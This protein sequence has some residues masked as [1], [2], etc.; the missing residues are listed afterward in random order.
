MKCILVKVEFEN[1]QLVADTLL[2][3]REA[4]NYLAA[5]LY[6]NRPRNITDAHRWYKS[7]RRQ[8]NLPSQLAIKAEQAVLSCYRSIRANKHKLSEPPEKK[9]LSVQLDKRIYSL[10]DGKLSVTTL[11]GRVKGKLNLFP[12]AVEIM[13][14]G[15][16]DPLLFMRDGQFWLS[17]PCKTPE[18]PFV[19]NSVLG[20]DLGLIRAAVTSEGLFLSRKAY[21]G[22]LRRF[23][24]NKRK[25]Q[26]KG[27][28]S[29]RQRLGKQRNR[30]ARM[31]AD[32]THNCVNRVLETKANTIAI[33]QLRSLKAK[34]WVGQWKSQWA[35]GEFKRI[36]GYKALALGKR[37][38]IVN[39]AYTS[40]RDWRGL[41]NGKRQGRRYY[42]TDGKVFDAD[43][44][45]AMNIA[46][47][48]KIPV[49][50][51]QVLDGQAHVIEPIVCQSSSQN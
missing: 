31:S 50:H 43:W 26:A 17:V 41:P 13:Q 48:A 47:L 51:S 49:S 38:I 37:V 35:F 10:S 45:A 9:R 36:L 34:K 28:K 4:F 40:Q 21:N 8:F 24:F 39:P 12:R 44:N 22:R 11:D 30:H 1:P 18:P 23:S 19:E 27:T 7:I 32:F 16:H 33:E 46:K 14:L 42:A 6:K 15:I 3:S 2:A 20:V 5:K 25:L 29:A